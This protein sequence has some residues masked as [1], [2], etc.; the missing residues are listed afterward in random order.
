MAIWTSK[1]FTYKEATLSQVAVRKGID[2]T[3][4]REVENNMIF[5]AFKLDQVRE[6][7]GSAVRVSSWYRSPL[8]NTAV[9]GAMTS[10]HLQGY[11][12]DFTCPA[13]GEPA[14][15]FQALK[16]SG[17]VYDQLILEF[18]SWVHISFDPRMRRENLVYNGKYYRKV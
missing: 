4:A 18:N 17:I 10:G 12:V 14:E 8:L 5:T 3:P 13:Y 7:L 15:I 1:Y 16:E 11:C 6:F 9:G 2:N